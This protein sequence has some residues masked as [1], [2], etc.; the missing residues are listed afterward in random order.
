[1]DE[2]EML[3]RV[4]AFLV[5]EP[6]AQRALKVLHRLVVIAGLVL[7]ERHFERRWRCLELGKD[8]PPNRM[9]GLGGRKLEVRVDAEGLAK[10]LATA[11]FA[12]RRA[13]NEGEMLVGVGS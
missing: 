3:V 4:G 2:G 7:I 11:A 12:A 8:R 10:F 5:A 1:M 6:L 9:P 13:M